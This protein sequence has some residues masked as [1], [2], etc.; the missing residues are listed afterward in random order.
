MRTGRFIKSIPQTG[1]ILS[2]IETSRF[3]TG[4]TWIGSGTAPGKVTR[5]IGLFPE[6]LDLR[7]SFGKVA[8][9]EKRLDEFGYLW[10]AGGNTFVLRRAFSSS[11]LDSIL[12]RKLHEDDFVYSGYSAVRRQLRTRLSP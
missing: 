5:A 9:L 12:H 4:V 6:E 10:V 2:T 11:G 8:D 1:A 3:V 7:S